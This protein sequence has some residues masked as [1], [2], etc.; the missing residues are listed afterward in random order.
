MK[1]RGRTRRKSKDREAKGV[2]KAAVRNYKYYIM[3]AA[4]YTCMAVLAFF[5]NDMVAWIEGFLRAAL[6]GA[7][8]AAIRFMAKLLYVVVYAA[9][10]GNIDLFFRR[11]V[12][13]YQTAED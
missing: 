13:D 7:T 1:E 2:R 5:A 11:K 6:N 12:L 9:V 3:N 10:L 4:F 8:T